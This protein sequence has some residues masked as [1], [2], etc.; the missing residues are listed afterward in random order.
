M[1]AMVEVNGTET[2]L[3]VDSGAMVSVVSSYFLD[4]LPK[5]VN[6][7]PPCIGAPVQLETAIDNERIDVVGIA[8]LQ[9][10]FGNN[11]YE[12]EAYVAPIRDPGL[13]GFDFLYRFDCIVDARN[14]LK[15][16][17]V[18][19]PCEI[20]GLGSPAVRVVLRHS[21][22]ISANSEMILEGCIEGG[23]ISSE[24]GLLEPMP[25]DDLEGVMVAFALIDH[26]RKDISIPLRVMNLTNEPV[27][28]KEGVCL[29]RLQGIE[30]SDLLPTDNENS[31]SEGTRLCSIRKELGRAKWPDGVKELYEG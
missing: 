17:G 13:L 20:R 6:I 9:L 11:H 24:Y 14:G 2:E 10:N 1:F 25:K 27:L 22:E 18:S 3:L 30:Q 26:N 23:T 19:V 29:A 5:V 7:R 21:T 12:W 28:L 8:N 4:S 31:S 15:I 16:G